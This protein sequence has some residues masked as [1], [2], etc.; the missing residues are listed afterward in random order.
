MEEDDK[1][2]TLIDVIR[3]VK[4]CFTEIK[5]NRLIVLSIVCFVTALGILVSFIS[6]PIYIASSTMML[7]GSKGGSV[8]GAMALANQFGLLNSGAGAAMNED[9]LLEIIK[10]ET[11]IKTALFREATIDSTTDILA[12]HFINLFG[13]SKK[14]K[15][16]ETLKGF[17]FQHKKDDLTMQESA[18]FKMFYAQIVTNFLKVDKSKSSII[19]VTITSPSELFSKYFNEQLVKAVISFYVDRITEKERTNVDIVQ[20]RVDSIA[21]ALR[22]AE[23]A[24]A[25]W[26][27]ASNQLVKAQGMI[28]EIKLRR[29]VEVNNS[30]YIEGIKQLEISK[31]TLMDETPFLQIIDEPVLP[32]NT[33][34]GIP[35]TKGI[36]A[37]FFIGSVLAG[38]YIWI[39]KK[40]LEIKQ[41]IYQT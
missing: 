15:S 11:I 36:L 4:E 10:A 16:D 19:T 35:V 31:F 29:N 5:K 20:K 27:D 26:K 3:F 33:K 14:W 2:I 12:N 24:L 30:M 23:L 1:G 7:E 28:T 39:R 40:Y 6:K 25:K 32:L 22:D 34:G 41:N 37:G 38:L 8:S 9:K 17:R 18:V 13:Y 21:V